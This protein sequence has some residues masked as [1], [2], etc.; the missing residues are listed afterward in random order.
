VTNEGIATS[1]VHWTL[2]NNLEN[3]TLTSTSA[4]NGTGNTLDN[5]LTGNAGNNILDG[6]A[7]NDILIGKTGTIPTSSI[8]PATLSLS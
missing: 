8:A 1:S 4:I 2:G 6:G 5:T 7:G 3:L